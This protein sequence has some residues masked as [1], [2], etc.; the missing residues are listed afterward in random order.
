MS[1]TEDSALSPPLEI[2]KF[3]IEVT[4][5]LKFRPLKFHTL[6]FV[7]QECSCLSREIGAPS[8]F[9]RNYFQSCAI[10]YASWTAAVGKAVRTEWERVEAVYKRRKI[11]ASKISAG[12]TALY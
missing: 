2:K 4:A 10:R 9:V 8:V 3:L 6:K 7:K 11:L 1:G 12:Q 5:S